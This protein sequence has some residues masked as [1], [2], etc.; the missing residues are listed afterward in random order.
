[1]T[2]NSQQVTHIFKF[3]ERDGAAEL[4][5]KSWLE[6]LEGSSWPIS[7][8]SEKRKTIKISNPMKDDQDAPI[9]FSEGGDGSTGQAGGCCNIS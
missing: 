7:T 1:M 5:E 2:E 6:Q 4:L 9:G 8:S 3:L